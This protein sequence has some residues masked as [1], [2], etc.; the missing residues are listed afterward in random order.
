VI[1]ILSRDNDVV[2][3]NVEPDNIG[4]TIQH[5]QAEHRYYALLDE[6]DRELKGPSG[7]VEIPRRPESI[8]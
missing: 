3:N 8:L 6:I 2:I 4:I 1:A 7:V 5:D